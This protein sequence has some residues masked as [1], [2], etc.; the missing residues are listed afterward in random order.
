MLLIIIITIFIRIFYIYYVKK[1]KKKKELASF[2]NL[3]QYLKE[4]KKLNYSERL[5]IVSAVLNGIQALH[6][7][8]ICHSALKAENILGKFINIIL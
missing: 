5:E 7:K 6:C 1:K 3:D 4:H 2:G 8:T